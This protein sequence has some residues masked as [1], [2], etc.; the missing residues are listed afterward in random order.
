MAHQKHLR[1]LL[2]SLA[3]P[4]ALAGCGDGG[5][6]GLNTPDSGPNDTDTQTDTTPAPDDTTDT[7]DTLVPDGSDP[8]DVTDADT[9]VDPVEPDP[10]ESVFEACT[11]TCPGNE[12]C[13]N[14]VCV[15]PPRDEAT[16]AEQVRD[17]AS[18]TFTPRPDATIELG[19]YTDGSLFADADGPATAT[20]AGDVIRFGSGSPTT[21]LCV[22]AFDQDLM[23]SWQ[24]NSDCDAL[25]TDDEELYVACYQ[26]D[27]CRCEEAFG[28]DPDDAIE[29]MVDGAQAAMREVDGSGNI[30]DLNSCFSAIGYCAG[31]SDGAAREGC[32]ARLRDR[33]GSANANTLFIGHTV[34][35]VNP[36]DDDAGRFEIADFPTNQSFGYKVSGRENRWRDTW[37]YG[38][39]SGANRVVDG[40]IE[41]DSNAV[42]AGAWRT[43]PP[44]VGFPGGIDDTRGAIAGA[45]RDCG[46]S[47]ERAPYN[48]IHATVGI[49]F[50]SPDTILAYFNGN[51]DNRLPQPGRIDTNQ[52][53]L[54]AA[55]NLPAG[56]NRVS[57][58][59]CTENCGPGAS[60]EP[61]YT[62]AGGRNV[63][64]TPKSVIIVTFQ[65]VDDTE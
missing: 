8:T 62:F 4:I 64:Q 20:L 13:V 38:L 36:D 48:I 1:T 9:D 31:I 50:E 27:P 2:F 15:E 56:P 44:S 21:G 59:I 29:T 37:E 25:R 5:S 55:I 39:F 18:L 57:P 53:G 28:G 41:I 42:S 58:V 60:G 11:D 32:V 63:F 61:S 33:T 35:M 51:P 30:N 65:G 16:L 52:D 26:L 47:G 24:L 46:I 12:I 34:S 49:A 3:I 23:L 22:A 43:I 10:D 6:Q 45:I 14:S 19:C 7:P 17:G 54:Y 40:V